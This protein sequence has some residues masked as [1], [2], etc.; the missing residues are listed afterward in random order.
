VIQ[1]GD[2]LATTPVRLFVAVSQ[3]GPCAVKFEKSESKLLASLRR[4]ASSAKTDKATANALAQLQ[5]YFFSRHHRFNLALDLSSLTPFQRE[6]LA[7]TN[8]IPWEEVWSNHRAAQKMG[9]PK[10]SRPL[11]QALDRNPMPIVIPCHRV[12]ASDGGLGGYCGKTGLDLTRWRL[13]HEGAQL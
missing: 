3:Q 11:G 9:R 2:R 4:Q 5:E 8:R 6:V 12:V 1:S 13:R 10:S 7:V